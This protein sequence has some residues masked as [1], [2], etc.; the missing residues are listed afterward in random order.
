MTIYT[1]QIYLRVDFEEI[2]Y[3]IFSG[4]K[5]TSI[6]FKKNILFYNVNRDFQI[7]I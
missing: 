2:E 1:K 3:S 6:K 5:A 7:I 4:K